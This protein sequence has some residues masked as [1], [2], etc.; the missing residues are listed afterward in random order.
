MELWQIIVALLQGLI[1][2]LPIS[3]EGQVVF[4]I[5]NF[6]P[7]PVNEIVSLVVWLHLGTALAVIARYPRKIFEIVSLR[8]RKLLK[9]LTI[10]TIATAATATVA[11]IIA[12]IVRLVCFIMK[13]IR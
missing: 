1:E 6:T 8:D 10:A 9:L 7:V 12:A 4:F 11:M 5:Y 2:W 3:S 13:M